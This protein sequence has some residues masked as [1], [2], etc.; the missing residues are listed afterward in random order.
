MRNRMSKPIFVVGSPRSGTSI[1][2]WCLG[3]HA[4]I[5]PVPESNWMGDFATHVAL[6]YQVGT[7][8]GNHSIL[9]AMDISRDEFFAS[10]GQSINDLVLCHR[11]DLQ[12]KRESSMAASGIEARWFEAASTAAGPKTRWVDATPEYSCHICGL[13]KLFPEALFIHVVRDVDAVVRSM[14]NFYRITGS[15][16][17]P[18]EEEAYK[19][20]LRMVRACLKAE[21]AYGPQVV[22][23]FPYAALMDNPESAMRSLLDFVGEPYTAK[24]LEPLAQRINS[25]NVP[26][27]FK[28]DDPATDPAIIQ[29]ARQ[30]F[31]EVEKSAEPSENSPAAADE[32]EATF[33]ERAQYIATQDKRYWSE[34]SRLES[35]IS[36]YQ[37][38]NS[39]LGSIVKGYQMENSRLESTLAELRRELEDLWARCAEANGQVT[40]MSG[41]PRDNSVTLAENNKPISQLT[42]ELRQQL[43]NK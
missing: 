17:A 42:G 14:L 11:N 35:I 23:R 6:S 43:G 38:E 22:Y 33:E 29:E 27:D 1:L 40:Q 3:Q 30:L 12:R 20:W 18:N 34:K 36:A 25:S 7:A 39:R 26:A 5:L 28:S 37:T 2:A 19:Y 31:A 10:L 24:C 13:R 15:N 21:E 8:R 4:N 16:L 32:M 9:S 41:Q